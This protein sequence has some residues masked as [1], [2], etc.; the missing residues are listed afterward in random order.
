M[1]ALVAQGS[2]SVSGL[3]TFVQHSALLLASILIVIGIAI[4]AVTMCKR[5]VSASLVVR[6]FIDDAIEVKVGPGV[7]SLVEERLMGALRRKGHGEE[8]Y[9]LDRVAIDIELLAGDK[10]L[11]KAITQ[12]VDVP[13]L[14]VVGALM[15]LVERMLPSR[16]LSAT[17]ELLPPAARESARVSLSPY[18]RGA[19]WWRVAPSGKA[20]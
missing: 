2:D 15:A 6:P 10:D 3:S 4:L 18:T 8:T 14:K 13:Q 1:L 7:A 19:G 11:S 16:G 12:L 5:L 17:G 20:K 9:D